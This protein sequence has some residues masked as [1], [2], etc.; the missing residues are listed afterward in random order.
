MIKQLTKNAYY[1]P[2]DDSTDRPSLGLVC[3]SKYSM[4]IDSGNSPRHANAF[5]SEIES[6]DIPPVKYLV[7]T[8]HHWDHVF[9]IKEMD[10]MRITSQETEK[11]IE[12]MRLLNWDDQSLDEYLKSGRFNDSTVKCIRTEIPDRDDFEIGDLDLVYEEK[13]TIDLGGLKCI[14]DLIGGSHTDDSAIVYIPK[15]R[16]IF[17]GDCIYGR[18]YDGVYGYKKEKLMPMIDKIEEYPADHYLI[19]HMDPYNKHQINALWKELKLA[20]RIVGDEIKTDKCLERY[21]SET[22]LSPS[23]DLTF[24]TKCFAE[25]NEVLDRKK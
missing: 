17:L 15:E 6:M 5:L 12:E 18:R 1:M 20:E 25:V 4:I 21:T 10:C 11:K 23:E 16:V 3:G 19:S 22:G 2:H 8:H 13:L 9:G 24:Y 14:V 7:I